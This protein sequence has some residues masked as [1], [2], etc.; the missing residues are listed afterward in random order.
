MMTMPSEQLM[1]LLKPQD[2]WRHNNTL[3]ATDNP[4]DST[5]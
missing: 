4:G 1:I 3:R 5:L 2:T